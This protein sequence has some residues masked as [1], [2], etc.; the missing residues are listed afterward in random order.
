MLN[1]NYIVLV[2]EA[3]DNA[4]FILIISKPYTYKPKTRIKKKVWPLYKLPDGGNFGLADRKSPEPA[5]AAEECCFS[6][7]FC[8]VRPQSETLTT[9]IWLG[10]T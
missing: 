9:F 3:H 2:I 6:A 1:I 7:H 4:M 8:P 10:F 5:A